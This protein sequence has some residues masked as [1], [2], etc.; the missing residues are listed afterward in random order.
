MIK[1]A[2]RAYYEKKI[3]AAKNNQ[4]ATWKLI[5]EVINKRTRSSSLPSRFKTGSSSLTD[6][7][8]IANSFCK[9]FAT[10]GSELA[11][12]IPH[13]NVSIRTF[14][15][16]NNSESIFLY[17][18]NK[19]ELQDICYSFKTDKAPGYDNISMYTI[20]KSFD[21][22]VQPLANII[23]QSLYTGI[24]P[25]KLKIAKVIPVYKS[26][27]QNSLT[28]YRPISLLSNFSKFFA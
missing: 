2:K 16:S 26:G 25:E 6:P 17:P 18:T 7:K 3:D 11:S 13:Q 21:L 20:K 4:K 1:N 23:N 8:D 22:I 24:F 9:Y 14:L 28:N 27:E 15:N 10:I 12:K 19:N 5:N